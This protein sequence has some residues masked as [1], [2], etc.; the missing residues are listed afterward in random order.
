MKPA[1]PPTAAPANLTAT[2]LSQSQIGLKWTDNSSNE[3]G[4]EIYTQSGLSWIKMDTVGP[5]ITAY[6]DI[7]RGCNTSVTYRIRAINSGGSS[8]Y[9]NTATGTTTP[10]VPAAPD[11]LEVRALSKTE[12]FL[13]WI[14]H[15]KIET[16]FKIESLAGREWVTVG[17]ARADDTDWTL[18][19]LLCGTTYSL[20]VS[21]C[22]A[23]GCSAPTNTAKATT[24]DCTLGAPTNLAASA[25]SSTQ[26]SLN[27]TDNAANETGFKIERSVDGSSSAAGVPF[28]LNSLNQVARFASQFLPGLPDNAQGVVEVVSDADIVAVGLAFINNYAVFTT[29]PVVPVP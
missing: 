29:I 17:T 12:I 1:I 21:A 6:T 5:N 10:C 15:S 28:T 13:R 11:R 18:S 3:T 23:V 4:F 26:I 24:F 14:D 22:N 25:A 19:Q 20:R 27:W 9:S 16:S 7:I 2:G 8:A